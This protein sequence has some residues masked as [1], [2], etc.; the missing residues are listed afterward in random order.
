MKMKIPQRQSLLLQVVESLREALQSGLWQE[1][2]PGE[3][4]LSRRLHVSR[5]SVRAALEILARE[6]LIENSPGKPRRILVNPLPSAVGGSP[7]V[8]LVAKIPLYQ[9]SRN[10]LFLI[11]ALNEALQEN[12]IRL[13][14]F[15]H[16]GLGS[17]K[18][19]VALKALEKKPR[20]GAY[21]LALTSREVQE[22]FVAR[23]IPALILGSAFPGIHLPSIECNYPALGRHAAGTLLG[24]GHRQIALVAPAQPLAGDL[25]TEIAFRE[26]IDRSG[27]DHR[28]CHVIRQGTDAADLLKK[29]AKLQLESPPVTALFMI[30][31]SAALAI[32]NQLVARQ[33]PVPG[34]IS[35]LCRDGDPLCEWMN[36]R[37]AHYRLP[38]KRFAARLSGLVLEMLASGNIPMRHTAIIPDLE[39]GESLGDA[40]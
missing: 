15:H 23:G 17:E 4:E 34:Q 24:K 18:P 21:I 14:I 40:P 2:L 20:S 13:E 9:M 16:E 36:P 12:D 33:T 8:T 28:R 19:H 29:W 1:F 35:L 30:Y 6:K 27:V 5:P 3:R 10:R 39:P 38:L 22:W 11:N 32:L 37:L 7:T 31:P 26:E 25:E